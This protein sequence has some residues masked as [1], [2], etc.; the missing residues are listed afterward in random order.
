[1]TSIVKSRDSFFF[2]V[3]RD[4]FLVAHGFSTRLRGH[5][6]KPQAGNSQKKIPKKPCGYHQEM[7]RRNA[8]AV[9]RPNFGVTL[10]QVESGKLGD[11]FC[12][13][14]GTVDVQQNLPSGYL[15]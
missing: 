1:M 12:E 8:K 2:G 11:F 9:R 7:P 4:Y 13:F 10:K 15:I 6:T 3:F 5:L 14:T